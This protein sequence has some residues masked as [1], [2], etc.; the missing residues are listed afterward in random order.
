MDCFES[1]ESMGVCL[2]YL[3]CDAEESTLYFL[4][5]INFSKNF[6]TFPGLASCC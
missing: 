6:P 1:N 2:I 3:S 4:S 5:F